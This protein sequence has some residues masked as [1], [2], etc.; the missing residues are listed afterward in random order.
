MLSSI[1]PLGERARHNNWALTVGGFT[2]ASTVV[3]ATVG[4]ILGWVGA[5]LLGSAEPLALLVSTAV[6]AAAAGALDLAR[7]KPPGPERQVNETWIGHYRGWVY[8]AAFG[9]ELGA[10]MVTFVVTWGVYAT[11]L[12]EL[13]TASAARGALIGAVF[14][15]GR[16][17][18]LLLAGWVDRPSRLSE[19]HRRMAA[20]GPPI[21]QVTG[22]VLALGGAVIVAGAFL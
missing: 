13:L 4:A 11:Y 18:A 3:G 10:G 8:G 7:V 15:L 9:A 16:S 6:V 14:G 19:F 1:H 2:I 20:L 17:L 12:A 22:A 21:R 5:L